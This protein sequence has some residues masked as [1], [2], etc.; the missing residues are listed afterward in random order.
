MGKH[1]I[2]KYYLKGFS[3]PE[4]K[5]K[6]VAYDCNAEKCYRTNIINVAQEKDF[7][8]NSIEK[9]LSEQI[10]EPANDILNKI[11][12]REK[13]SN[14][15]KEIL[16]D[17]L[18]VIIKR[19]PSFIDLTKSKFPDAARNIVN[20]TKAKYADLFHKNQI[21]NQ[22]L[23]EINK[24]IENL[25]ENYL[26]DDQNLLNIWLDNITP[27]TTNLIRNEILTKKWVFYIQNKGL[28]FLTNDN[29]FFFFREIG[30]K[31]SEFSFP[32]TKDITLWATHTEENLIP[33][34]EPRTQIIK[35]FNRRT[36][37][38][39]LNYIYSP[40]EVDWI[41]KLINRKED[42]HLSKIYI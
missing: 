19:V 15:D 28:Y 3:T 20:Q 13:L 21:S 30:L 14:N 38:N 27:E 40:K 11:N 36:I 18:V 22:E 32:I 17:Y 23:H 8:P 39:A 35:E 37:S 29:P 1:Y 12:K 41:I 25:G 42:L 9:Y 4:D 5:N 24:K 6:I 33:Y 2:P 10:E 26:D 16:T 31:N 34:A 7:Y